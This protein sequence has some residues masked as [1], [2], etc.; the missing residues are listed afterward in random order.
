VPPPASQPM[1]MPT[2]NQASIIPNFTQARAPGPVDPALLG[3]N[4]VTAALN[5]QIANRRG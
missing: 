2:I 1:P 5:A 3:D 4:P